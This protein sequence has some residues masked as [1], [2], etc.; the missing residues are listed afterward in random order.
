MELRGI[1]L[2]VPFHEYRGLGAPSR[3]LG[4]LGDVYLDISGHRLFA[5]LERGWVEWT[6]SLDS[7]DDPSMMS[8]GVAR[9]QL[10]LYPDMPKPTK[11]TQR[12]LWCTGREV[13]WLNMSLILEYRAERISSNVGSCWNGQLVYEYWRRNLF[14]IETVKSGEKDED[15]SDDSIVGDGMG[16]SDES[17]EEDSQNDEAS[18][19]QQKSLKSKRLIA[20]VETCD[21][22]APARKKL[23]LEID[24]APRVDGSSTETIAQQSKNQPTTSAN[25]ADRSRPRKNMRSTVPDWGAL[26]SMP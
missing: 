20:E 12:F 6:Y 15:G 2:C 16:V 5:H 9:Q 21:G 25:F 1:S 13:N 18:S 22:G 23:K 17:D 10:F 26:S 14:T 7:S 19:K 24:P 3:T 4:H 11:D 8:V